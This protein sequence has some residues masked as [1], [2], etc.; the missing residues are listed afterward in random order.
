M[1]QM[2]GVVE[3]AASA[4]PPEYCFLWIDHWTTCMSKS[5]WS[6]WAQAIGSLIGLA[7]AVGVPWVQHSQDRRAEARASLTAELDA[8]QGVLRVIHEAIDRLK[9]DV[10]LL[11]QGS[12]DSSGDFLDAVGAMAEMSDKTF[13]PG[14]SLVFLRKARRGIV[15]ADRFRGDLWQLVNQG[16]PITEPQQNELYQRFETELMKARSAHAE[17]E[18]RRN[19]LTARLAAINLSLWRKMAAYVGI[20]LP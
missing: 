6:G 17:L 4:A 19:E 13:K 8:H 15:G 2:V 12:A 7:I 10:T 16:R 14:E 11:R 3:A 9:H 1:A 5:E 20:P 18:A